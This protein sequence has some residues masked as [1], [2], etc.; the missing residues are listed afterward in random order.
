MPD[1]SFFIDDCFLLDEDDLRNNDISGHPQSCNIDK[2]RSS[3]YH[4]CM[5]FT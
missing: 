3:H 4:G 5:V 1:Y 2:Q